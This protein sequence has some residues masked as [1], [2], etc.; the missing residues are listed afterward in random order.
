MTE[1]DKTA[2]PSGSA[3]DAVRFDCAGR[4]PIFVPMLHHLRPNLPGSFPANDNSPGESSAWRLWRPLLALGLPSIVISSRHP[5]GP[6]SS[7][8]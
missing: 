7:L 8:I 5:C 2:V 1:V 3:L 6:C 4:P